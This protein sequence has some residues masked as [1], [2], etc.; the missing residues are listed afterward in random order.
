MTQI[1]VV[2]DDPCFKQTAIE[3]GIAVVD[4]P[5]EMATDTVPVMHAI[6]FAADEMERRCGEPFDYVVICDPNVPIRP[7]GIID[8]VVAALASH[9]AVDLVVSVESCGRRHPDWV[10]ALDPDGIA[11][12]SG[13]PPEISQQLS[14]RYFV[15][16][17]AHGIRRTSLARGDVG[18]AM[19]RVCGVVHSS[20][21][22]IDIDTADELPFIE[23]LLARRAAESR[24]VLSETSRS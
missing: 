7:S 24:A 3:F 10:V 16:S 18:Y 21:T 22:A 11:A 2:T 23:F 14:S 1:A 15:T 20:D 8:R 4:E 5:A 17:A 19:S 12:F 6:A 13:T 9:P